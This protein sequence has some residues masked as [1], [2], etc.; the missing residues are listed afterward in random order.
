MENETI[1]EMKIIYIRFVGS[2]DTDDRVEFKNETCAHMFYA[3]YVRG[4]KI[5]EGPERAYNTNN[6]IYVSKP[7]DE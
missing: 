7:V 3:N 1:E 4:D 6:I 2:T 5:I